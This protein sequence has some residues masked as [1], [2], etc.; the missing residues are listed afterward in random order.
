M[1]DMRHTLCMKWAGFEPAGSIS[2]IKG[3]PVQATSAVSP[4]TPRP[5]PPLPM[6]RHLVMVLVHEDVGADECMPYFG[7][8]SS[9]GRPRR[10]LGRSAKQE[11]QCKSNA[12]VYSWF[13][14]YR[15]A[16]CARGHSR[17]CLVERMTSLS[18]SSVRCRG[19]F[20]S[21]SD[22]CHAVRLLSLRC[23]AD[24]VGGCGDPMRA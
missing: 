24:L 4:C 3:R 14:E 21:Q 18:P 8:R 17:R 5:P 6:R 15:A 16:D 22:G 19:G 13:K 2:V 1:S 12:S 11:L 20:S 9:P 7:V 23:V 10:F